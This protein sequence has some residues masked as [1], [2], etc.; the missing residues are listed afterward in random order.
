MLETK[1]K[2]TNSLLDILQLDIISSLKQ[3]LEGEVG[4]LFLLYRKKKSLSPKEIAL[5]QNISKGRVAVLI[6]NLLDKEYIE[7]YIST[8]DRRSFDVSLSK[9][10]EAFLMQKMNYVDKYFTKMIKKIGEEKTETLT[11]LLVQI[12]TSMKEE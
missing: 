11:N 7:V 8:T 10:G 6:N 5:E 4:L 3:F 9:S 1:E 12:V 2:F